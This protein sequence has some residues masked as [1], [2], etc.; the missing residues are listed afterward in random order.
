MP[1][2]Q[3]SLSGEKETG[4]V[5]AF[6]DGIWSKGR[7]VVTRGHLCPVFEHY[8]SFW[9]RN[10]VPHFDTDFSLKAQALRA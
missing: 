7:E 1:Q 5:V 10:I 2:H 3:L 9:H 8:P 6:S 4:Q